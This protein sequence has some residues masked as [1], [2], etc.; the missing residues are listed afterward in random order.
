MSEG[1]GN[2]NGTVGGTGNL[3]AI[4]HVVVL[5]LENRSFDHMLGYLYA[6]QG[7]VSPSGQPFEG[8]TGS[9]SCPDG[10]G[11]TVGVYQITPSTPN[12]YFMPGSDPGEGYKA[13]ND[14]LYGSITAPAAGTPAPMTGF[15]TDYSYTLGW[16][17]KDPSYTVLPG[18]VP[19]MIMGCFTPAA[20]P[21]LS[22]L[23]TGYAVCDHW[24]ASVPT[25]TM[26]NRAFVCAATSMGQVDDNT[27]SFSVA[28]DLR[29]AR[30]R[31]ADLGH[32]RLHQPPVDRGRLHRHRQR[33]RRHDR[34]V[35]RLPGCL[36]G[37]HAAELHVP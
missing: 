37:G 36:R 20:L 11:G 6:A 2:G 4:N 31:R 19:S 27:K 14:Q 26:P 17:A 5:M 29:H 33:H 10:R 24:F 15:V 1:T 21:V 32:L 35:H 23:A 8:L 18:T 3:A 28:V 25:E 16:Q 22:A 9:E 34:P 13:T 7:N 12:A 30:G